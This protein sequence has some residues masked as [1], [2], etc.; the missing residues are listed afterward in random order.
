[1]VT[2][3]KNGGSFA[4]PAGAVTEIANG[5]YAVAGNATDSATLGPLL[6]H[7]GLGPIHAKSFDVVAF[8]PQSATSLGVESRRCDYFAACYGRLCGTTE[9]G[10]ELGRPSASRRRISTRNSGQSTTISI[11]RLLR[12]AKPTTSQATQADASGHR[13]GLCGGSGGH[14]GPQVLASLTTVWNARRRRLE[15]RDSTL[16]RNEHRA[17]KGTSVTGFN[18]QTTADIADAVR[19]GNQQPTTAGTVG[20]QLSRAYTRSVDFTDDETNATNR[21]SVQWFKN[22]NLVTKRNYLAD[23][24]SNQPERRI[25][26]RRLGEI[27]TQIGSTGGYKYDRAIQ[28]GSPSG[29]AVVKVQSTIDGSARTAQVISRDSTA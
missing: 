23:N 28:T 15:L 4:S 13:D 29:E 18:D 25:G 12:M 21:Y 16:G 19:Q 1:M 6:L 7:G 10:R 24:S 9:R 17:A 11:R 3:S 14:C 2:I 22:G 27:M 8:D 20:A 26:S 5:W